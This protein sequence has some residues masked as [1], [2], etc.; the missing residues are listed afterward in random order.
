MDEIFEKNRLGY[1][2]AES[3][4][5]RQR[6]ANW[7]REMRG[8]FGLFNIKET[9]KPMK[10]FQGLVSKIISGEHYCPVAY[11]ENLFNDEHFKEISKFEQEV[12]KAVIE[13]DISG[14]DLPW[15]VHYVIANKREE[16]VNICKELL[17]NEDKD[18]QDKQ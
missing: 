3:L 16:L 14:S 17:K 10:C 2:M 6:F 18:C 9:A 1:I 4:T 13:E 7:F 12:V 15:Q 11:I 5:P 8:Q